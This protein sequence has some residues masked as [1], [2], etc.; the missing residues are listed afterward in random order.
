MKYWVFSEEQLDAAIAAFIERVKREKKLCHND[1][2]A[3]R[4]GEVIKAF[5]DAPEAR[6]HKLQGGASYEP[7]A[8]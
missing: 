1:S 8:R 4:L 5:L 3:D 2:T 6:A 7:E